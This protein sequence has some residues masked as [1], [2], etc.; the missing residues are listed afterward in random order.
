MNTGYYI[1]RKIK[2][3]DFCRRMIFVIVLQT[4]SYFNN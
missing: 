2:K 3:I 4:K 1:V